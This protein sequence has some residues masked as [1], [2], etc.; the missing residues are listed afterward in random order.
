M[1]IACKAK[2][3]KKELTVV[4][5]DDTYRVQTVAK[6]KLK[7]YK[8]INEFKNI[9]IPVPLNTSFKQ[10]STNGKYTITGH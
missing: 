7:F 6:N 10:R 8:L 3:I 5:V 9:S 1:L 4:H 2:R